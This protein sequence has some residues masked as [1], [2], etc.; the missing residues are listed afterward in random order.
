MQLSPKGPGHL[1]NV[2]NLEIVQ[3]L[4]FSYLGVGAFEFWE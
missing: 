1:V 2:E 3:A 4:I